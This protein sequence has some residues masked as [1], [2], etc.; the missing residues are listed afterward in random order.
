MGQGCTPNSHAFLSGGTSR[1]GWCL[2][3]GIL[4]RMDAS[5]VVTIL[6]LV[7]AIPAAIWGV[8]AWRNPPM[9]VLALDTQVVPIRVPRSEDV[10]VSYRGEPLENP[11]ICTIRI[12][13]VGSTEVHYQARTEEHFD[14]AFEGQD[15]KLPLYVLAAPP[16]QTKPDELTGQSVILRSPAF[17]L[18]RG[19]SLKWSILTSGSTKIG[20]S[21]KIVGVKLME[22]SNT[23]QATSK[24][25]LFF[26]AAS[27]TYF[28]LTGIGWT[29]QGQGGEW[30]PG[31]VFIVGVAAWVAFVFLV[32]EN[33]Q[34]SKSETASGDE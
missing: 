3:L 25:Y 24:K 21:E 18:K 19:E 13:N 30:F 31:L 16:R 32:R 7:I 11:H 10:S 4:P 8:W 22:G 29:C 20:H 1:S 15:E 5:L 23:K 9:G 14:L 6:G 26:L 17:L 12:K 34:I 27:G 28:L 2:R 33:S